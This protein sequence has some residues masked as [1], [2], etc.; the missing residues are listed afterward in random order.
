M[1]LVFGAGRAWWGHSWRAG[2]LGAES[3]DE[4]DTAGKQRGCVRLL[5][6]SDLI[7]D[8]ASSSVS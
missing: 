8:A 6:W 1:C 2:L 5:A 4:D 7:E 3:E